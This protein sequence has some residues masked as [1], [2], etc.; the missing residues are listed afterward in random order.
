MTGIADLSEALCK[1]GSKA[2][3]GEMPRG[4]GDRPFRALGRFEPLFPDTVGLW[5][6]RTTGDL[7]FACGV[8]S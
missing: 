6:H 4:P 1:R 5:A 2:A 8:P 3:S 7:S